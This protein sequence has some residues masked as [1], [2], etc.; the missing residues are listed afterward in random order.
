M[1]QDTFIIDQHTGQISIRPNA[2]INITPTK[3]HPYFAFAV[4]ATDGVFSAHCHV[5]ITVR[6]VNDHQP[7]FL[8][9]SYL[10]TIEENSEIGT[11]VKKL[12]AEDV[13]S[14]INAK[15]K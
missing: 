4:K 15:I 14:G 12:T 3:N 6:D 7:H 10:A 5:N 13:D 8:S 11:S 1:T 2:T 9:Q